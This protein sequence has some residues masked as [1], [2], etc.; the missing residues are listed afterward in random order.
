MRCADL[1][2]VEKAG[3]PFA[4]GEAFQVRGGGGL[5]RHFAQ[6]IVSI[7]TMATCA[8]ARK[9][10]WPLGICVFAKKSHRAC[11][12]NSFGPGKL[13]DTMR[14]A[15]SKFGRALIEGVVAIGRERHRGEDSH[16]YEQREGEC[17]IESM[18]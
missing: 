13:F 10:P 14:I 3:E 15:L 18:P 1:V 7:E 4:G 8:T 6:P 2:G 5:R 11:D 17:D 12:R 9:D 16:A